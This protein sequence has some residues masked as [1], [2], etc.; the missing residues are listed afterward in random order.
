MQPIETSPLQN[1]PELPPEGIAGNMPVGGNAGGCGDPRADRTEPF[2]FLEKS[3]IEINEG[4]KICGFSFFPPGEDTHA[5]ITPPNRRARDLEPQPG[6]DPL[7]FW[8]P[9]VDEPLGEYVITVF[10]GDKRATATMRVI[11]ASEPR[12]QVL[13]RHGS[14]GTTF[15]VGL[16][17]F[18]PGQSI[19]LYLYSHQGGD[20]K[21]KTALP[22]ITAD[23]HGEMQIDLTTRPGDP[24]GRYFVTHIPAA[25]HQH[26]STYSYYGAFDLRTFTLEM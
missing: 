23:E 21:Y 25:E 14:I 11:A 5:Q 15:Q 6:A 1:S 12:A 18:Q 4:S 22:A 2:V 8:A 19:A 13:P 26:G 20:F 3:S 9:A 24:P 17:G 16:A 7:W 10:K